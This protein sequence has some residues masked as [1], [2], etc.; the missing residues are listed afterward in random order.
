SDLS[1]LIKLLGQLT[2]VG[3]PNHNNIKPSIYDNIYVATIIHNKKEIIIGCVTI[4][5][6]DKIIHNGGKVGHIEDVVVSNDYRGKGIGKIIINHCVA[7]A[8]ESGCYKVILDCNEENTKFYEKC[9]F[10]TH[11]VCMRIDI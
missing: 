11:G 3:N 9:G 5:I 7:L 6:E 2:T 4:L 1:Q 10:K 8:K